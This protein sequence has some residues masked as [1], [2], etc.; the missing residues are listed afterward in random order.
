M[1]EQVF[2]GELMMQRVAALLCVMEPDD[3]DTCS[4]SSGVFFLSSS[5][6]VD[7]FCTFWRVFVCSVLLPLRS[8][9]SNLTRSHAATRCS[10]P[11]C[12]GPEVQT[13]ELHG[14]AAGVST[15]KIMEIKD[16]RSRC[17]VYCA[18]APSDRTTALTFR[19]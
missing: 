6:L 4:F 17:V 5:E 8:E 7:C 9:K 1:S 11:S 3:A 19:D 13:N 18:V 16:G 10:E 12:P 14:S 15:N 2:A